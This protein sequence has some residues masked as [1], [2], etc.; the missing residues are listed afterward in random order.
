MKLRT[1]GKYSIHQVRDY[2]NDFKDID[3]RITAKV[4]K[5]QVRTTDKRILEEYTDVRNAHDF[6][7]RQGK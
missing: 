1:K 2:I 7:N 3:G 6:L 4:Y 5:Y